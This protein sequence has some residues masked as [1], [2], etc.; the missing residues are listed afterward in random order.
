[1]LNDPDFLQTG[2]QTTAK[3]FLESQRAQ[4]DALDQ[5]IAALKAQRQ[6]L[7]ALIEPLEQQ[8]APS[9]D[10]HTHTLNDPPQPY[11]EQ[12]PDRP[13]TAVAAAIAVLRTADSPLHFRE[14]TRRALD[15]RLWQSNA[16]HPELSIKGALNDHIRNAGPDAAFRRVGPGIFALSDAA[17]TPADPPADE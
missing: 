15:A 3:R 4:R 12:P 1:M 2:L 9:A 11:P 5:Q 14:I 7:D 10:E 17:L 8:L 16:D 13:L 6:A